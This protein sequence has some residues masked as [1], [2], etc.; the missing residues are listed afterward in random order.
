LQAFTALPDSRLDRNPASHYPQERLKRHPNAAPVKILYH[1]RIQS[2]D[3]QAVHL[4]ELIGALRGQGH[5]VLLVGPQGFAR[6]SFGGDSKLLAHVKAA[7]PKFA[8]ELLELGYNIPA[9]LR[10]RKAWRQ[11]RPDCLYERHNLYLLA[12]MWLKKRKNISLLLEVNAPLARERATHGGLALK[13]LAGALERL[14]WR[15]AD[16]VLPVTHVLAGEIGKAGVPSQNIAVICNAIDSNKFDGAD[17]GNAKKA[18]GLANKTVLGFTG[19]V[20]DW[21][22]L[23]AIVDALA[24]PKLADMQLVVAGD[25]PALPDLKSQAERLGVADRVL[26]TGLVDRARIG[27]VIAAFDIA[28]QPKCVE[29]CSPLKL[30]EYMAL[31]KAIVAPDQ[32]NIREVLE[33]EVNGLLFDPARPEGPVDAIVRLASDIALRE[34]LGAAARATV[35]DRGFTWSENARRVTALARRAS[36]S[37]AARRTPIVVP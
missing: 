4:E 10:L 25:G 11:F 9:Y 21:H 20:R 26:F 5:D 15:N 35:A 1:H 22:G 23:D 2:R 19:F 18:L 16:Y 17:S 7:L 36:E 37:S 31:G 33:S 24:G 14:V 3:G 32:P 29:Y 8:Y 30:F 12:G 28:L 13:N 34:R 27:G 6:A